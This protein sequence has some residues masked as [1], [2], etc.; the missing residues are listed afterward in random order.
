[1]SCAQNA[2]RLRLAEARRRGD[3]EQAR[4]VCRVLDSIFVA[5]AHHRADDP[6]IRRL[7]RQVRSG[8]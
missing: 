3:T 1:M 2:L 4:R 5:G 6:E 8:Q 7:R